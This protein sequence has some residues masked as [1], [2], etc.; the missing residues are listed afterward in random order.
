MIPRRL[1]VESVA[2][3]AWCRLV[4]AQETGTV[5]E[6]LLTAAEV[7]QFLKTAEIIKTRGTKVGV[8]APVRVTLSDGS[9]THDAH[10]QRVDES[11][12]TFQSQQGVE[13]NFRDSW[14]FNVAGYRM[15]R[16]LE[17]NMTPVSVERKFEGR[18]GAYTWWIDD[19]MMEGE[20]QR[21]R[22]EPPEVESFNNQMH[23][24][25]V[26][27]QLIHN[28][29]RNQQNILITKDWKLWMIDHTRAFRKLK[30]LRTPKNLFRCE[31]RLLERMRGLSLERLLAEMRGYL[32][33]PEIDGLLF[34]R[35]LIVR[36]FEDKIA[37]EGESRALYDV[38]PRE[39]VYRV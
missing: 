19:A 22:I 30:A 1:F 12:H 24:I 28:T 23:I 37:K 39:A 26:F 38:P 7:E 13:L 29:D 4:R 33:E 3:S 35:D 2:G 9:I 8:T 18:S 11:K 34:R 32:T 10:V 36:F 25:R 17:L 31:R 16:L 21:K 5:T 27:D 6:R 20:R 14:K 15:D